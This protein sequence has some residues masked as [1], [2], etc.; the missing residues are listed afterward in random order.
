MAEKESLVKESD[1]RDHL[2]DKLFNE[3]K[4][5]RGKCDNTTSVM[6]VVLKLTSPAQSP[7]RPSKKRQLR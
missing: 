3:V 4:E 7:K 6:C 5:L 1:L 2:G